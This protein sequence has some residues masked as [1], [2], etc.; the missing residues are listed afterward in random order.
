[1]FVDAF[2]KSPIAYLTML[3][4]EWMAGLLRT[5]DR[6]VAV[7]AR[8]VGWGDADFAARQFR[9]SVWVTPSKYRAISR[10]QAAKHAG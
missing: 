2:G 7:I 1:V 4:T 9:R 6:P 8:E 5:T 3:R 10:R